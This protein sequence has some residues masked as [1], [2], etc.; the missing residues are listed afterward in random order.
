MR[1]CAQNAYVHAAIFLKVEV[2][3]GWVGLLFIAATGK[4]INAMIGLRLSWVQTLYP[5]HTLR[6]MI[7]AVIEFPVS[8][9]QTLKFSKMLLRC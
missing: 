5:P 7:C 9:S 3:S 1:V 8:S 6:Q 2:G 4:Q